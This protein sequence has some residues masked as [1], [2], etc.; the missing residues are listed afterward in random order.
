[1]LGDVIE[2]HQQ[3]QSGHRIVLEGK[4]GIILNADNNRIEQVVNNFLSNAIKYSPG[5]DKIIVKVERKKNTIKLSVKD[6]GIGIPED[7]ISHV[8]DRF[9]RVEESG[10]NFQGLGLGLYISA[11]IIR[12]HN[13]KIGVERNE[14]EGSTFWFTLPLTK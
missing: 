5:A 7:Q 9:Y 14:G 3:S 11:E 10:R 8:F 2:Q 13:G 1:M 4:T 12:R 6:F